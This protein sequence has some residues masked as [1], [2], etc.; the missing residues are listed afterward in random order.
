MTTAN[1]VVHPDSSVLASSVAARL[2]TRIIDAQAAR[3]EASVVLTGGRI[4]DAVHSALAQSP[5]RSAIDWSRVDFWWGDERFLPSGDPQRN[6]VQASAALLDIVP[7]SPQRVH[8]MPASDGPCSD[9]P[10][11]AAA[12]YAAQ[13]AEAAGP[14]NQQHP[15]FDVLMLGVGEDA[16]VA[17]I[18]P[19]QPAIYEDRSVVAVR[20]APK[21]PPRRITMSFSAINTAEE[22]WLMASGAGK[23]GAVAMA[24]SG[25]GPKQAPAAGVH[26]VSATRWLLD[27]AAAAALPEKF[28][29]ILH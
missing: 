23:A 22:I 28:R 4:A 19:E 17:S 27:R 20:G 7:V 29:S 1:V 14:G 15:H 25:A 9:D 18:F 26:G 6:D 3:G 10:E 8:A 13:L 2:A 21:P 12:Q 11:L 5:I 24:M 16:H